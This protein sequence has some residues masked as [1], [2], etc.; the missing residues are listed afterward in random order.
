MMELWHDVCGFG[1]E[2]GEE[3][4]V[5]RG[6]AVGGGTYCAYKDLV[7]DW[8]DIRAGGIGGKVVAAGSD[9]GYCRILW[10]KEGVWG[11]ATGRGRRTIFSI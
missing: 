5:P 8:V 2:R 1:W 4:I 11:R 7:R 3:E 6:G 10:G 9:V